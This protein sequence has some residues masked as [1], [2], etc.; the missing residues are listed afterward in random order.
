[1]SRRPISKSCAATLA[2]RR[3]CSASSNSEVDQ[4]SKVGHP[5]LR[6]AI[7]LARAAARARK[8]RVVN[9]VDVVNERPRLLVA[10]GAGRYPFVNVGRSAALLDLFCAGQLGAARI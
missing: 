8:V 2:F 6:K 10:T 3:T 9:A 7:L 5:H 4:F 1:M